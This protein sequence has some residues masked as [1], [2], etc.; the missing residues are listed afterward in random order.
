MGVGAIFI[1]ALALHKLPV[2]HDPPEN[3]AELLAASLE[4]IVA[5]VVLGSIFIRKHETA[6]YNGNN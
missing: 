3:E 5:F 4:L 2:P 6:L 1:S